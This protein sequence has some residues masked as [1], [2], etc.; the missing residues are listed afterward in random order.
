MGPHVI[1]LAPTAEVPVQKH[2]SIPFILYT[3]NRGEMFLYMR[4]G[5][6]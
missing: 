4:L 1:T 5:E 3:K 2:I 6:T